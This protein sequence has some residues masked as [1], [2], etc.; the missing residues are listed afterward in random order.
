MNGFWKGQT[1]VRAQDDWFDRLARRAATGMSRR[2]AVSWFLGTTAAAAVGS[3]VKPS[4]LFGAQPALGQDSECPAGRTFYKDGCAKPVPKKNYTPQVNGCGPQNGVNLVP[5]VPLYL[6]NFSSACDAHDRGYGTCNRPK[7]VTDRK[8]LDDMKTIC[9]G[10]GGPLEGF[11]MPLLMAQCIRNAEIY[12]KA[13]SEL[14]NDPYKSGQREGCD[15]C[16]ECPGEA[17]KC[18]DK[19]CRPE[20]TCSASGFCCSDCQPGWIKCAA[21]YGEWKRCGFACCMPG[22]PVCCP[23]MHPGSVRCC[24]GKCY[25]GGCG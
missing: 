7:E 12:Y 13:V 6:A 9:E 16:F 14:G 19:C 22:S 5:Q 24:P 23:G 8:F 11:I 17:P 18:G 20:Q 25:K 4:R 21:D 15:C 1:P 10:S 3:A 2:D